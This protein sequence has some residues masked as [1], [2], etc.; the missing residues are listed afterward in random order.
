MPPAHASHRVWTG[1]FKTGTTRHENKSLKHEEKWV[2]W[3]GP[4]GRVIPRLKL[5]HDSRHD[6]KKARIIKLTFKWLFYSTIFL[7][8]YKSYKKIDF[9]FLYD[10]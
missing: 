7:S 8:L 5:R 1:S 3:H 2:G 4:N 9:S 10:F 6:T